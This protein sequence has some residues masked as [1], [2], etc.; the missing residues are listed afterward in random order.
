MHLLVNLCESLPSLFQGSSTV[1]SIVE[2]R[3][4]KSSPKGVEVR[5]I[6]A[7]ANGFIH[8]VHLADKASDAADVAK[9]LLPNQVVS[10]AVILKMTPLT[11]SMKPSYIEAAM[12]GDI[13]TTLG[14]VPVGRETVATVKVEKNYGVF[15]EIA[16]GVGGLL[17]KRLTNLSH[18][19]EL[20]VGD[21][22]LVAAEEVDLEKQRLLFRLLNR[23][24]HI[25]VE[26]NEEKVSLCKVISELSEL[27][28]L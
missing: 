17:P 18:G 13:P 2:C 25:K 26:P 19:D 11:L 10:Q 12:L 3:I 23:V 6:P 16:N 8:F 28:I 9:T 5:T 27:F 22:V 20:K 24:G 15:V 14:E 1:G 7:G 21:S 4:T